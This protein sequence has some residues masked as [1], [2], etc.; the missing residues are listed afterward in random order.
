MASVNPECTSS[1]YWKLAASAANAGVNG[2][3]AAQDL[4]GGRHADIVFG[5][6]DAG[7]EQRDQFQQLLLER[8][9]AARDG[10]VHL[11]RGDARLVERG[12]VDQIAHGFGLRQIDAAVQ[13][14]AQREFARLGQA[15]AGFERALQ[16]EA[17]DDRRAVAGDLDHVFGGVGSRRGE[18]G[19]HHFIDY[20]PSFASWRMPGPPIGRGA[21]L[22]DAFGDARARLRRK[23]A[24]RRCRL[25]PGAWKSRRWC[26]ESARVRVL[27]ACGR[28][29][30]RGGRRHRR[31]GPSPRRGRRVSAAWRSARRRVAGGAG[32]GRR[33]GSGRLAM[34]AG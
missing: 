17:Q 10:A 18:E 21:E 20:R 32:E 19:D 13:I 12:G 22:Q 31:G 14:R 6:I 23:G 8:R 9:D 26:R 25:V 16:R 33:G 27:P 30:G 15:R 24:L 1:P 4:R 5:E 34:P 7:F 3:E 28:A 2:R 11:L 29:S